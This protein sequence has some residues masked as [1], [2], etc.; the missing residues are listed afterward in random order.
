MIKKQGFI[1]IH[2]HV[3]PFVD[4]GSKSM[5]ES[6]LMAKTAYDEG[7]TDIIFTPHYRLDM[8]LTP[9]QKD[10]EVFDDFTSK[11]KA[12]GV[13]I[14][15]YLGQELHNAPE[16]LSQLKDGKAISLN[17]SKYVLL[18]LSWHQGSD[19][20]LVV[21]EYLSAGFQPIIVHYERYPYSTTDGYKELRK[22]GALFQ[23]N[24][25]SLF[26]WENERNKELAFRMIEDGCVDFVASD[27]HG[28]SKFKERNFHIKDAYELIKEKFGLEVADNLFINNALKI[29]GK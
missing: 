25:Y 21:K 8:F 24:A 17:K 6:L 29:L 9:W 23:I 27:M 18:E 2:S 11:L 3:L 15:C 16:M 10:K 19:Y 26:G 7:I 4:D 20:A 14:N 28:G 13:P 1:D 12:D 22:A 5:E